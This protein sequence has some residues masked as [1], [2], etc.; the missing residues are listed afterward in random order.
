MITKS[1]K[2]GGLLL[3]RSTHSHNWYSPAISAFADLEGEKF[4]DVAEEWIV[5]RWNVTNDPRQWNA[6][7]RRKRFSERHGDSMDHRHGSLP[8]IER[9]HTYLEWHAMWCA[10]GELMQTNAL[11]K[12]AEDDYDALGTSVGAEPSNPPHRYGWRIFVVLNLCAISYGNRHAI[13]RNG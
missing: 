11:A 10:V 3:I 9:F 4:L 13:L 1:A 8:T 5:D 2:N 12:V 6:E 7:P